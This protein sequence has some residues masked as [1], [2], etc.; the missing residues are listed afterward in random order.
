VQVLR[1]AEGYI[2]MTFKN[3]LL[4][5]T[6]TTGIEEGSVCLEVAV[7]LYNVEHAAVMETYASLIKCS[8]NAAEG[9]N[10]IAPALATEAP[11]AEHVWRRVAHLAMQSD[12][13]LAHN[14][15]FDR[16][17]VPEAAVKG[18][19]WICTMSDVVWPRG[20]E[21]GNLVATALA[22]DLGVSHAHRAAVD[23]DLIARCLTRAKELG[24][25]L[26]TFLA[27]GM[28]PKATY[29]A[30]VSYADRALAKDAGFK[31]DGDTKRWTRTMAVEDADKLTFKTSVLQP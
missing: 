23:V 24:V 15:P 18:L 5:D 27:R 19:P 9:I 4:L 31:W 25:D 8:H 17:F 22:M 10:R 6:E 20:R 12:A 2:T 28:R 26:Q 21:G 1:S 30:L 11:P 3:V 13:V 16:R 29:Q 14:A 7:A